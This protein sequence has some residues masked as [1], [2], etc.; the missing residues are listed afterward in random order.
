MK[1]TTM[2]ISLCLSLVMTSAVFTGCKKATETGNAATAA[3]IPS[4]NS[5]PLT[6]KAVTLK[7][8][9]TMPTQGAQVMS[10]MNDSLTYQVLEKKTGVKIDFIH[11]SEPQMAEQFNLMIAAN[12][13]PD[14]IQ[15]ANL[16][17][18]GGVKAVS[19]GAYLKLNDLIEK[20]APNYN[21]LR[22]SNPDIARQ[23]AA[24][25]G[26]IW[27]FMPILKGEN[28]A[29]SGPMI[30]E[31][32]LKELGL[33]APTTMDE[34]YN[35]LKAFKDKKGAT[36][37]LFFS[38]TGLE[39]NAVFLSAYGIAPDFYKVN[40]KVKYGPVEPQFKDYLTTMNKWYKEG[41]IDKDFPT[42]TFDA[43]KSMFTS[44][45]TGAVNESIDTISALCDSLGI[46]I[47]ALP[48]PVLKNGDKIEFRAKDWWVNMADA[49]A[50]TSACKNPELAVKWLDQAYSEEG[51]MLFN[52]GVEG[53]S[54]VME[55]GK[56]KF[57]DLVMK[58]K[59]VPVNAAIWK[60]RVQG[61]PMLRW[62]AYS[63]PATLANPKNLEVKEMWTKTGF[64]HMIPPTSLTAQEGEKFASIMNN[65]K[66]YRDE[67]VIKFITGAA[68][69][70]KFDEYVNEIKKMG[71]DEAIKL[72][73]AAYDRYLK[74]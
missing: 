30:K 47:Q 16:Y 24:D 71:I 32:W 43:M 72:Q 6:D 12:D 5:L 61:A 57:T 28:P 1:K 29:W 36:A 45:K 51:A 21:K 2:L 38:K 4:G 55:N 73:Q 18:G 10:S 50:I 48:Y 41:L 54:Y 68:D 66:T 3:N 59:D 22:K 9:R 56:P 52:F 46:K 74:R 34:W 27:A 25:D 62:G 40:D 53:Q 70:S 8:W 13:L 65:V 14:I 26:T 20:Y 60:F 42:R 44:D 11:A 23:T 64:D 17:K 37:P 67:M 69:L 19:D 33:T 31:D 39:G 49:T 15:G 63:N 35:V 7:Y 58:N